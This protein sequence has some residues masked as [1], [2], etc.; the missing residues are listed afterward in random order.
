LNINPIDVN[1]LGK[2]TDLYV[3]PS[4]FL[5][6][7][8]VGFSVKRPY[9]IP[10]ISEV[11]DFFEVSLSEL[12]SETAKTNRTITFANGEKYFT[13]CYVWKNYIVWGATAMIISELIEILKKIEFFQNFLSRN[14]TKPENS[15]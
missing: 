2:I 13:P 1:I 4:N 14:H 15:L 10:D 6:H 11:N 12:F 9:F 5:I 3:P 8:V 7:P